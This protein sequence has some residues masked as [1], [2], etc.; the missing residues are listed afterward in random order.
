MMRKIIFVTTLVAI[1]F[2]SACAPVSRFEWGAYDQQLFR[3][4]Q[5]PENRGDYM[6][7]LERA[8][9]R[10]EATNRVAPGLNAELGY[11]F[12]E[13]GR[14]DEADVR[15]RREMELFP[16]SRG[17]L[18]RFINAPVTSAPEA[19]EIDEADMQDET[20]EAPST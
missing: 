14:Y 3:Y 13:E 12:W 19:V 17:F 18:E 2:A 5:E 15:F 20:S 9:E 16:E 6:Q 11:L 7:A 4:H 10:G 8:I 1:A